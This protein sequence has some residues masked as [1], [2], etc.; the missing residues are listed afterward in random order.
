MRLIFVY[1]AEAG[2]VNGILDSVHKLVS[3]ATYE[4]S[5]CAITHGAFAMNRTWRGYIQ[6]LTFETAFYHRKDFAKAFPNAQAA[7]PA[8]FYEESGA[9]TALITA[10]E[11]KALKT[12]NVLV[13]ALNTALRERALR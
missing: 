12:V 1:N 8:I 7:L 3:P 2:L 5:L 6:G 4:C 10:E 9:L 11:M 13:A